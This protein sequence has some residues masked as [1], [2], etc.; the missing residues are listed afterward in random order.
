MVVGYSLIPDSGGAGKHRGG[1]EDRAGHARAH[2]RPT[3]GSQIER[4]HCKPWDLAGGGE[5]TGNEIGLRYGDRWKK[6]FPARKSLIAPIKTGDAF[7]LRSGGGGGLRAGMEARDV[8]SVQEDVKQGYV[9]V[10]AAFELYGV[11]I[12][13]VT[14]A[15]DEAETRRLNQSGNYAQGWPARAA[16]RALQRHQDLLLLF[17][18]DVRAVEHLTDLLLEHGVQRLVAEGDVVVGLVGHRF[19]SGAPFDCAGFARDEDD[20]TTASS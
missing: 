2:E 4:A 10:L 6:I 9:S 12:D 5:A 20:C 8:A 16:A 15:V 14:F 11:A 19:N 1:L 18:G 3:F 13:P 17:L 7:R